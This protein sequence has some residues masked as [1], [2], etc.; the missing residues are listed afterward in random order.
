MGGQGGG[1]RRRTPEQ[2]ALHQAVREGMAALERRLPARLEGEVRR[3]LECGQ[4]RRGFIEVRCEA[5]REVT[6]LAFSCKSRLCAS[7]ATR[8]A[9]ETG[10]QLT[11]WLP[12]VGYRQW[13]LSL[14][15]RLRWPAVKQQGL[16]SAVEQE[17]VRS[18]WRWQRAAARRLGVKGKLE[19][20]ATSFVQLF[21][22]ALQLTPHLHVLLPE[23]LWT[24]GGAFVELPA[25]GDEDVTAVLH[26]TLRRL[27]ARLAEL[28]EAVPDEEDALLVEAAAPLALF[29][30]PPRPSS[31]G[32]LLAVAHGFSLHAGTKVHAN[33]RQGLELLCRY[34][35]RGAVAESRLER[36]PDGRYAYR[37][38]RGRPFVLEAA[39]LLRRLL[40]LVP[41]KGLHLTRFR[42][43][44]AAA[45][46]LRPLV[47]LPAEVP[48]PASAP[49]L[50]CASPAPAASSRAGR[51]RLDWAA[52]QLRT[53]GNDVWACRCGGRRA[54]L[55]VVTSPATAE[56]VLARLG[57][58]SPRV[59]LP[60][61]QAP[62]Q[63][64]LALE[65]AVP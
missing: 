27:R 4:L 26:R 55:A 14:P 16:L 32:R 56:R 61:A 19:G 59:P 53:F 28:E 33:D 63:L 2:G 50:Q 36:L 38:K 31:S 9:I 8:R 17:L 12:R 44:F 10:A 58:L 25:P 21:G 5:C 24:H 40:A 51:P 49:A 47:V 20:G 45:S 52:V 64:A 15:W 41:P 11:A 34:G 6:L 13:T 54:V 18:V 39:A 62:P 37:P 48:V 43:V 22:S 23:G 42:G 65:C 46:K 1:Y 35:A 3:F 60:L 29:D 57:L 7:C 30:V